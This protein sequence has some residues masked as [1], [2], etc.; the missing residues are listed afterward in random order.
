MKTDDICEFY[1]KKGTQITIRLLDKETVLVE[2]TSDGLLFLSELLAAHV[3]E[4][5]DGKNLGPKDAGSALFS[6][7]STMGIYIH[8]IPCEDITKI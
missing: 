8:Q 1:A 6:D 7:A 5:A 2:G 3:S 4:K